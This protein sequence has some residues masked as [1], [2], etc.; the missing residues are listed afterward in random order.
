MPKKAYLA[1]YY[2]CDELKQKYIKYL[3]PRV[4]TKWLNIVYKSLASD[5]VISQKKSVISAIASS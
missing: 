3:I 5:A 1:N 2:S 4:N